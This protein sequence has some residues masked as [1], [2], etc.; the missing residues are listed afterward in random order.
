MSESHSVKCNREKEEEKYE[1]CD[2]CGHR[3]IDP[4][5][6]SEGDYNLALMGE[7]YCHEYCMTEEMLKEYEKAL[8]L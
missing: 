3:D 6:L 5:D 7:G 4:D 1:C 2:V 8:K